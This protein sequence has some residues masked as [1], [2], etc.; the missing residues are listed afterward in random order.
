MSTFA[1][2]DNDLT[3]TRGQL[4]LVSGI[5]DAAAI[6]L[7]NRFR[8]VLG[9]YFLDIRQGIPYFSVVFVKNPNVL[10][11]KQLFRSVIIGTPGVTSVLSL[12]A[13]YDSTARTLSF[14][15]RA[16]AADGQVITGGSGQPFIVEQ[17]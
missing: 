10:L 11:I 16:R 1:Q 8:F 17:S 13:S 3:L 7:R 14:S 9:E 5:A 2:T 12:D 4:V 6:Q 15:F